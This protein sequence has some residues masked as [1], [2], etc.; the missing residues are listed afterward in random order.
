[1]DSTS[2][3]RRGLAKSVRMLARGGM[4][5]ELIASRHDLDPA[6]VRAFL[7]TPLQA[8][9]YAK[10]TDRRIMGRLGL[11]VRELSGRGFSARDIA[12]ALDLDPPA[13]RDFLA[14]CQGVARPRTRD[15]Q[16]ARERHARERLERANRPPK[17]DDPWRGSGW[18]WR[19]DVGPDGSIELPAIAAA[20]ELV[21]D[22]AA[23]EL[24][25]VEA[26]AAP[27]PSTW[28]GPE[29]PF[30]TGPRK[31]TEEVLERAHKLH[32]AGWSWP[33]IAREL[34]CHRMALYHARKRSLG[35]CEGRG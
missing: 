23:A 8:D 17:P 3:I 20:A 24:P 16:E 22:Q 14:R 21:T 32:Q 26:S 6:T 29:S 25:R 18:E 4:P 35:R 19:E 27:G 9:R 2:K 10:S 34:G 15:E 33:R 31:I 7:A 1:M 30:V 13:V 12:Y 28:S 5:A 11:R